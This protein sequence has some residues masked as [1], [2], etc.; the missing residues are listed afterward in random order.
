MLKQ[1]RRTLQELSDAEFEAA[2]QA[3]TEAHDSCR[4]RE[5][6]ARQAV[7]A[8]ENVLAGAESGDGRD[9]SNKSLRERLADAETRQV[10]PV[11]Q[12]CI[13]A[14]LWSKTPSAETLFC[15]SRPCF[16]CGLV[17]GRPTLV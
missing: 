4:D 12:L 6:A 17:E 11:H 8:A 10:V 15:F 5:V 7:E 3:A 9:E 13:F 1:I 14:I 2:V 16:H